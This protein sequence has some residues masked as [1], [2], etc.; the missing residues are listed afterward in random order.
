MNMPRVKS[1]G[2]L[3]VRSSS[4]GA[5]G[6]CLLLRHRHRYDLPKGHMRGGER[7]TAAKIAREQALRKDIVR[8]QK[9]TMD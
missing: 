7:E 4:H 2:V 1:C 9:L 5:H 8:K 3:V 6:E